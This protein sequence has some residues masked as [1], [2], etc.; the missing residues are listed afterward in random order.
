MYQERT[1]V[2]RASDDIDFLD[3]RIDDWTDFERHVTRLR[4]EAFVIIDGVLSGLSRC[5]YPDPQ[6]MWDRLV[7]LSRV[8]EDYRTSDGDLGGRLKNYAAETQ[9]IEI[10]LTD[11]SIRPGGRANG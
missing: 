1:S 3:L 4:S 5:P 10:A 9:G 11:S 8:A 2:T 7:R 6:R